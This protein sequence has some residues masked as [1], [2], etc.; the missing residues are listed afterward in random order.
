MQRNGTSKQEAETSNGAGR[1]GGFGEL[2]PIALS[3][4]EDQHD[5]FG[6]CV[7]TM[8]TPFKVSSRTLGWRLL[9]CFQCSWMRDAP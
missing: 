9:S 8:S 1:S 6:R 2:G 3:F 4:A 7:T 5:R